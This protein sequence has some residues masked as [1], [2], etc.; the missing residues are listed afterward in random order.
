MVKKEKEE[1]KPK[2]TDKQEIKP[3]ARKREKKERVSPIIK[4]IGVVLETGK[5][6]FGSRKAK[7]ETLKGEVKLLILAKI[8]DKHTR[9]DLLHYSE[10]S[11]IPQIDFEGNSLELGSVCGKSYPISALIIY[12]T[13]KSKIMQYLTS[14][15][16]KV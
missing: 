16:K 13:G 4:E 14:K 15:K 9:E 2:K 10:L 1:K 7:I 11:E 6:D 3:P 5:Y 12:D 8:M